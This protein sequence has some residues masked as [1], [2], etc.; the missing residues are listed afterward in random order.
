[1]TNPCEPPKAKT[2]TKACIAAVGGIVGLSALAYAV[3]ELVK[4]PSNKVTKPDAP[5]RI[6]QS[7]ESTERGE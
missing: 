3:R 5:V 7:R 2:I 4:K 1:M 6:R